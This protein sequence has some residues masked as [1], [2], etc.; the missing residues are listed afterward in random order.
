MSCFKCLPGIC[1]KAFNP[2]GL[3]GRTN[4][5]A[6]RVM[7]ELASGVLSGRF[8]FKFGLSS[9][10]LNAN[11]NEVTSQTCT[12]ALASLKG[13]AE[14]KCERET[15]DA[16]SGSGSYL[17][18]LNKFPLVPFENNIFT[19]DGNP[20]LE[21]F[22]CNSS[23]IDKE[24]AASPSCHVLDAE[25]ENLPGI[26]L[27]RFNVLCFIE[28]VCSEY[29]E[30]GGHGSCDRVKGICSCAKGYHGQACDDTSDK[31]VS[32][33]FFNPNV[34]TFNPILGQICSLPRRTVLHGY[35]PQTE[36]GSLQQL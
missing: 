10:F 15:F 5:R 13:V 31:E 23:F 21:A 28:C 26:D 24:D 1:S 18:T 30:C 6:V 35:S 20:P 4:R 7:T 9:A 36:C 2:T 14:V 17:I 8:E 34:L 19:H 32:C 3:T 16:T 12:S 25:T 22:F 33:L 29:L 27:M 11:A